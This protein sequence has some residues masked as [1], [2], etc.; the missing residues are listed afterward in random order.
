[1]AEP[2][3]ELGDHIAQATGDAVMAA[4]VRLGELMLEAPPDKLVALLAFLPSGWPAA[5]SR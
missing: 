1:M 3:Q 2:L 4:Y 5:A